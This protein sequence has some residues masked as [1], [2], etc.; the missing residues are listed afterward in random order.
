M[1]AASV[2]IPVA[3]LATKAIG[4]SEI[5]TIG[6]KSRSVSNGRLRYMNRLFTTLVVPSSSV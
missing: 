4:V 6:T 1:S 2:L 5:S 3:G